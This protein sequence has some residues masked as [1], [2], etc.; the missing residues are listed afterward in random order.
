MAE[1]RLVKSQKI[2]LTKV[3]E[4]LRKVT[5]G[6]GW[7]PSG[8]SHTWDLDQSVLVYDA[9]GNLLKEIS[10]RHKENSAEFHYHGDDLYGG[11]GGGYD[12]DEKIDINFPNLSPRYSRLIV[13]MNIYQAYSKGQDLTMVKD[14]YIHLWDVNTGKDLVEYRI[15][16]SKK[17]A[18][19]TGMIVGEFIKEDGEWE[20]KAVGEP[21]RVRDIPELISFVTK[22]YLKNSSVV[23]HQE[24]YSEEYQQSPRRSSTS[25]EVHEEP[26]KK[27]WWQKIFN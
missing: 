21:V 12:D 17:F 13:I 16:N 3:T 26:K 15:E 18:G 2:R 6:M 22:E 20:F 9:E 27:S 11:S 7:N 5:A 19:M 23:S 8:G 24:T 10:Y 25:S 4:S 1:V 14:A